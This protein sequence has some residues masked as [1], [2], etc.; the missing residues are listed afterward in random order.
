MPDTSDGYSVCTSLEQAVFSKWRIN[1]I[2][3]FA[4]PSFSWRM[5]RS[6]GWYASI[7][8]GGPPMG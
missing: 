7:P 2:R 1:N 6:R 3:T 4:A 8:L 5:S